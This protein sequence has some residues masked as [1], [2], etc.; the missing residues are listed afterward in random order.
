MADGTRQYVILGAMGASLVAIVIVGSVYQI[1]LFFILVGALSVLLAII[2]VWRRFGSAQSKP[3]VFWAVLDASLI[4]FTGAAYGIVESLRE[5]WQWA[6]LL[7]LIVPVLMGSYLLWFALRIRR[8]S[9][10]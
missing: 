5:G 1:G 2:Y 6:D 3:K 9:A 10:M 8:K 7:Y 4:F